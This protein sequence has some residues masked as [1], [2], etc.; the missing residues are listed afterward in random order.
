MGIA[1]G[2]W[3]QVRCQLVEHLAEGMFLHGQ[4]APLGLMASLLL[5]GWFLGISQRGKALVGF[6]PAPLSV[7]LFQSSFPPDLHIFLQLLRGGSQRPGRGV[8]IRM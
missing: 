2:L 8:L 7:Q 4:C 1:G 6:F 5:G 3:G